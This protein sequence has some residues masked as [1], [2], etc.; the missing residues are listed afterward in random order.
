[1]STLVIRNVGTIFTGDIE[2]P[3][4]NGPVSI[5]IEDGK[6]K[7]IESTE[8]KADKVIDAN[9]MTYVRDSSFPCAL[10][11]RRFQPSPEPARLLSNA[12]STAAVK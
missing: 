11:V 2:K 7:A 10:R 1:M 3:V 5:L 12:V 8:P 6:I 9:G 4:V